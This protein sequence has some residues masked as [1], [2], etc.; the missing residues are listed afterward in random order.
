MGGFSLGTLM[1]QFEAARQKHAKNKDRNDR[2]RVVEAPPSMPAEAQEVPIEKPA[3]SVKSSDGILE[4]RLVLPDGDVLVR[5][6]KPHIYGNA[7]RSLLTK[8]EVRKCV[9]N[10][11]R[12]LLG[13]LIDLP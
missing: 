8:N 6:K 13:G 7:V 11:F 4:V 12:P 3:T 1:D 10:G 5:F 9:M 2:Y